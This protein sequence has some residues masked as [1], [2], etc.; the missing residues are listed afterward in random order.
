MSIEAYSASRW[1]EIE[2]PE[3]GPRRTNR[4]QGEAEEHR[5]SSKRP[6][7]GDQVALLAAGEIE[8]EFMPRDRARPHARAPKPGRDV[9]RARAPPIEPVFE[10]RHRPA[11]LERSAIPQAGERGDL[12]VAGPLAR[13]QR[14]TRIGS[15]RARKDVEP[16]AVLL[17][18][19]E[20]VGGGQHVVGVKRRRV[21]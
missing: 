3:G 16:R 1:T 11:V 18:R 10:R 2:P 13:P 8:P 14:Q 19:R 17:G 5:Y 12:V 7:K 4:R 21:T 6:E 15:D 9:V 20:A